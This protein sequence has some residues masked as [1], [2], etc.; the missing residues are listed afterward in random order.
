[1]LEGRGVGRMSLDW[2][3]RFSII[4]DIERGLLFLHHSLP[5]QKVPHANLNSSNVLIHKRV[6]GTIPSSQTM[7]SLAT[8]VLEIVTQN[9]WPY[10]R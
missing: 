5:S 9:P 10:H 2:T 3:T 4:K 7:V 8:I 1:V 6:K